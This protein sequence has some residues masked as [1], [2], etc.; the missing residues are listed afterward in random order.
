[1]RPGT[2]SAISFPPPSPVSQRRHLTEAEEII[3]HHRENNEEPKSFT[4]FVTMD[5][6]EASGDVPHPATPGSPSPSWMSHAL[7]PSDATQYTVSVSIGRT[8]GERDRHSKSSWLSSPR[9]ATFPAAGGLSRR[10][11]SGLGD[12]SLAPTLEPASASALATGRDSSRTKK[13]SRDLSAFRFPPSMSFSSSSNRSPTFHARGD[14]FHSTSPSIAS[15]HSAL[16][17]AQHALKQS[18]SRRKVLRDFDS[19]LLADEIEVRVGDSLC[20]LESFDDGWCVAIVEESVHGE[21]QVKMGCVPLWVFDR[22]SRFASS[23][24]PTRSMR[25]TSLAVTIE[26]T[27]TS[28]D[29]PHSPAISSYPASIRESVIS[30]NATGSA[31]PPTNQ[32]RAFP[33]QREPVISWS[34]F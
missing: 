22:P 13:S 20:V 7:R 26:L 23:P 29:P 25:S 6:D 18:S 21:A 1:M 17:I 11:I 2:P 10:S 30:V 14:G 27:P 15:T 31:I 24:P 8:G 28:L 34:N 19:P 32:L 12:T 5:P 16:L 33:W 9:S 3:A 4:A